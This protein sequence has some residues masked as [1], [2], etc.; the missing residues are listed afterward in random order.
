MKFQQHTMA[1]IKKS[2]KI[3][4][5]ILFIIGISLTGVGLLQYKKV[6]QKKTALSY[7]SAVAARADVIQEV[8]VTGKVKAEKTI[9]LAFDTSGKIATVDVRV[10]NSVQPEQ[11][12]IRMEHAELLAQLKQAQANIESEKAKLQ[13][14]QAAVEKEQA[15]LNELKLG[16]RQEEIALQESIVQN[17]EKALKNAEENLLNVKNKANADIANLYAGISDIIHDALAKAQDAVTKQA[18]PFFTDDDT[19]NPRISFSASDSTLSNSAERARVKAGNELRAMQ[20]SLS[21]ADSGDSA[22]K[23]VVLADTKKRLE[24]IRTLFT[25]LSDLLARAISLDASTT[26]QYRGNITIALSNINSAVTSINTRIQAI[27]LQKITNT[28]AISNAQSASNDAENAVAT[29]QRELALKKAGATSA[30]IATQSAQIKQAQAAVTAQRA[31]ITQAEARSEQINVQIAKKILRSPISAVVTKIDLSPGENISANE[32]A[33]SLIS[34]SPYTIS[35][36]IPEVDIEKVSPGIQAI[37]TLDAYGDAVVFS[38]KVT[39]IDPSETL[40]EGVPTYKVSFVFITNYKNRVKPGMTADISII[41]NKRENVIAIKQRAIIVK[42][43]KKTVR[44]LTEQPERE[45]SVEELEVSTGLYGSDGLVEITE[46][47]RE[48][49]KVI[50]F[51]KEK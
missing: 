12:L 44:I 48:G 19:P 23:D 10:G 21:N 37:A 29:A 47:I 13:E 25:A 32:P 31:N 24:N 1:H 51:M 36:Y 26:S 41:T 34:T 14:S 11:I 9:D 15:Q 30:E 2:V 5:I 40:I 49:D 45:I 7:E 16:T 35:A 28:S 33:V 43:G 4:L 46:G 18:D 27:D 50:V 3:T 20:D 39:Q 42:D 17:K 22:L 8:S 6:F 38:A